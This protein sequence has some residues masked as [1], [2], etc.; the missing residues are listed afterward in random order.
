VFENVMA[1]VAKKKAILDRYNELMMNYSDETADE[2]TKLAGQIDARTSGISTAG[3]DGDGRAALPAGRRRRD[4]AV[5]RRAPPRRA[6]RAAAVQARPAA[7][8]RTDQPPR[9]RIG[10]L[11]GR[12]LRDYPG[13]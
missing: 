2:M 8:R 12:H 6:L 3:R 11:A 7:A 10:R 13:A 5:G 1:G 4:Q 9:R